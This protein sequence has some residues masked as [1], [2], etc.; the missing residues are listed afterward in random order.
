MHILKRAHST[1]KVNNLFFKKFCFLVKRY[2]AYVDKK[3]IDMKGYSGYSLPHIMLESEIFLEFKEHFYRGANVRDLCK[4]VTFD[5]VILLL[6][7]KGLPSAKELI[8]KNLYIQNELKTFNEKNILQMSR[9]LQISHP[10]ELIR[11]SL[12][13]FAQHEKDNND[14]ISSYLKILAASI[15]MLPYFHGS[16]CFSPHTP[17]KEYTDLSSFI[18][19]NY[20]IKGFQTEFSGKTYEPNEIIQKEEDGKEREKR[21]ILWKKE[22]IKLLNTFLILMCEHGINENTFFVRML[23]TVHGYNYFNICLSAVTFYIDIFRNIDLYH[24]MRGFL[25]FNV[26]HT[27]SDTSCSSY[28]KTK[29][30]M[31]MIP[32]VNFFFHKSNCYRKKN[33][34][35]KEYLTDYCK[36]TCQ[37]NVDLLT[38]FKQIETFFLKNKN[39]YPSCYYYTLLTFHLINLPLQILPPLYFLI[40]LLSFTAHINEQVGNNKFVKYSGVYI[41]NPPK[42]A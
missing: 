41:G 1:V 34:I 25:Q 9:I 40:R 11:I 35:F 5:H 20:T 42:L 26:E 33:T 19:E 36:N 21:T 3:G 39:K 24:S 13:Q 31:E 37:E 27:P 22:K 15:K 6:L 29:K 2:F 8:Q 28:E 18:I 14:S 12:L 10:L 17:Q 38:H 30:S 16:Q 7:Q 23:S 32:S 4:D